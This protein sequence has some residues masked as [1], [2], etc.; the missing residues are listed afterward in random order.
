M[1]L[2]REVRDKINRTLMLCESHQ[3]KLEQLTEII[4]S[5]NE[6]LDSHNTKILNLQAEVKYLK[7]WKSEHS[8]V[9]EKISSSRSNMIT[10]LFMAIA[11]LSGLVTTLYNIFK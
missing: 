6:K 2:E 7:E 11:A 5:L 4:N 10:Q 1:N 8:K 9:H 3:E